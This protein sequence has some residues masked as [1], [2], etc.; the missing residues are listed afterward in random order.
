MAFVP[1]VEHDVFIS[2]A[3]V[4]NQEGWVDAFQ[5]Q[6]E[7]TLSQR[8]GRMGVVEIWRDEALDGSQ[9]FD[10]AIRT[11]IESSA[12]FLALCSPGYFGSD[13]C[14]QELGGF[15][16]TAG[17]E[18]RIAERSRV[19]KALLYNIPHA[20]WP[21]EL[22]GT[23]GFAFHDAEETDDFGDPLD[24]GEKK[25]FRPPMR[26]LRDAVYKIL[27]AMAEE[28]KAEG[29]VEEPAAK[30]GS[31]V[32][33]AGVSDGLRLLRGRVV[34]D[35]AEHG[36]EVV[37][38]IPPPYE[39]EEHDEAVLEAVRRSPLAVH[40]FDHLGGAP[41]GGDEESTYPRRQL[42]LSRKTEV[43]QLVWVPRKLDF[44]QVEDAAQRQFL[45]NL[46]D[47]PEGAGRRDFVR[48]LP[49]AIAGSIVERLERIE[50][51]PAPGKTTPAV[52][53]DTHVKDQMIAF[54]ASQALL[55]RNVQP[56]VNPEEDD[57]RSN[58][59]I[60]EQRLRQVQALIIVFGHASERWVRTRLAEA[61][62]LAI[63][64]SCPLEAWGV[65][66]AP[67]DD[68]KDG[69]SFD[70]PMLDVHVLDNRD[71]FDPATLD[72]ILR[73]LRAGA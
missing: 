24:P 55:E 25:T 39:A 32:Y 29:R 45:E 43:P 72:P 33:L 21:E 47:D 31:S 63:A 4:D 70:L 49:N 50:S 23:T 36:I 7:L 14:A 28:R 42:E 11:R 51:A 38:S 13:Y 46:E 69:V 37:G 12:V 53:L 8:V 3:H 16:Q 57:P 71:G 56:Y 59:R 67:P 15:R 30:A 9:L 60:L 10:Q 65:Y 64:E 62:K 44:E 52:L 54:Q 17:D 20:D 73:G 26:D 58:M 41:V 68:G 19:V 61:I 22:G 18:L 27:V 66:L 40:L 2:Y 5:R 34:S 35:L 48:G 6:L 1:G